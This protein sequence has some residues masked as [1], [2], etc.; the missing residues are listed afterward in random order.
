MTEAAPHIAKA[1]HSWSEPERNIYE[2]RRA[3]RRCPV[4]KVTRHEP[5]VLPWVE[6]RR[7]GVRVDGD[8]RTP[9]CLRES[10]Q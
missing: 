3:C 9:P 1:R 2:T 8:G 4:V 5:G 10:A 7:D 6:F